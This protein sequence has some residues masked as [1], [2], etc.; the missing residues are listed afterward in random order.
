MMPLQLKDRVDFLL[1]EWVNQNSYHG[2]SAG[3]KKIQDAVATELDALGI[4]NERVATEGSGEI[5]KAVLPSTTAP[6]GDERTPIVSLICHADTVFP[7]DSSFQLITWT[8]DRNR[9]IGPGVIDDKGGIL[10]ILLVL[11]KLSRLSERRFTVQMICMPGEEIGSPGF[12]PFLQTV[13]EESSV[14]LGF[15]PALADGSIIHSRRGNR[16]YE[17]KMTGPGGH[18]GRDA[19]TVINPMAELSL[20]IAELAKLTDLKAGVSVSPGSITTDTTGFNVIPSQAVARIDVR[21]DTNEARETIHQKMLPILDGTEWTLV[22]D[23]PALPLNPES[24]AL[25]RTLVTLIDQVEGR[26]VTAQKAFGSSDCNYAGRRGIPIVD[27]LGPIG[28]GLHSP[29]ETIEMRSIFTRAEI[30]F[31]CLT[32]ADS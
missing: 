17:I 5:L 22:E 8:R 13:G 12:H 23:C 4:T 11:E 27:G 28:S 16:W 3:V 19:G 15:E 1:Q 6:T 30:V 26:K 21:Y 24:E 32:T 9:A 2:N 29:K 14:I 18:A 20:K 31:R 7:P 25:A 10:V